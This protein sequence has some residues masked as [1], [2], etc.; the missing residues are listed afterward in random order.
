MLTTT[1]IDPCHTFSP[2]L[3]NISGDSFSSMVL[4]M[5]KRKASMAEKQ[6]KRQAK[7]KGASSINPFANLPKSKLGVQQTPASAVLDTPIKMSD[8]QEAASKAKELLQKQRASVDMLTTVRE[9]VESLPSEELTTALENDGYFI[10]DGFLG[11]DTILAQ[12]ET[13][14]EKLYT[15]GALEADMSNLGSGEYT[16]AIKGGAEQYAACPRMV[17]WVVSTT[18]HIPEII[19]DL[20]LDPS[21]CMATLR[22][23]DRKVF[24]ASLAL[25]T[26]S[27]E[28]PETT[29]PFTKIVTDVTEDKRRLTLQYYLVPD[30]WD[31]TCGGGLAFEN[32]GSVQ[33]KRDRLVVC[34]SDVSSL[35]KEMWKGNDGML[36][37]SCL[38]HHLVQ[39]S[40]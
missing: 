36:L 19:S 40:E 9:K 32:G 24:Q 23:F 1:M 25:L 18:K 29:Q 30:S 6:K 2:R 11:D 21:A 22:T 7:Q 13:E 4:H 34:K 8:P 33:A 3:P 35:R 39:K 27:D 16:V 20:S 15:D 12:M 5:A 38:E 28:V 31:E 17:E 37:G 14:A 10:V 26:G